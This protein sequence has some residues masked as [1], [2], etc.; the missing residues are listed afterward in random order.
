MSKRRGF[1]LVE[2]LVVIGIVAVL[3]AVLLPALNKAR[4]AA[5]KAACLSN[6]R[7]IMGAVYIYANQY[8]G[9]IP[10]PLNG[11]NASGSHI[12]WARHILGQRRGDDEGYH[13]LG[14]V[15][16]KRILKDPRAF[17]CPSQ[18]DESLTY[19]QGWEAYPDWKYIG[20]SY[21]LSNDPKPGWITTQDIQEMLKLK[22]GRFKGIKALASDVIGPRNQKHHWPHIQPYGVCV[23]YSDGHAEFVSTTKSE[24]EIAMK[25][26]PLSTSGAVDGFQFYMFK[27]FD[28]KDFTKVRELFAQW[29]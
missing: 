15:F 12:V 9:A 18:L 21:R 6:Q 14:H 23:G 27:A 11:G 24:Y 13:N 8:K 25:L 3:I 10:P 28:T 19:P 20:Y 26:P 29:Y 17:Y 7:Q 16:S 22:V 2:L 4:A 5:A 1:T